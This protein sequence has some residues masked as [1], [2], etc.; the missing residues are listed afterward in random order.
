[1]LLIYQRGFTILNLVN[2]KK[3]LIRARKNKYAICGFNVYNLETIQAVISGAAKLNSPVIIQTS[4]DTIKYAG[5]HYLISICD[6]AAKLVDIPVVLHLDHGKDINMIKMAIDEGYTSVMI[7]GSYLPYEENIRITSEIVKYAHNN[8]VTVEAELGSIGNVKDNII[9]SEINNFTDPKL[10]QY[11][12]KRT[13]IDSLAVAIGTVH[14]NYKRDPKIDLDRLKKIKEKINLPLVLHGASGL[15]N[16]DIKNCISSG[17]SKVN[18]ATDLKNTF[19]EQLK[20]TIKDNKKENDP[21]KL[22]NPAKNKISEVVM[23]KIMLC[24][25]NG[26]KF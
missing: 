7:D 5:M 25:L 15:S 24:G 13:G 21:R 23:G 20:K 19:V 3:I 14:G 2:S 11:F 26:V 1:M 12:S 10:V 22:F 18:I 4:P 16:T 6:T 17:I 8:N 9:A